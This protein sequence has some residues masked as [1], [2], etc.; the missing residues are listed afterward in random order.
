M[1]DK[2]KGLLELQRKAK[3]MQ[4]MMDEIVVEKTSRDGK[5]RLSMNGNN[6]LRSLS[7]DDSLL[8]PAHKGELEK[9]LSELVSEAGE[10]IR[11]KSSMQ[12][13]DMMKN[14]DIKIPGL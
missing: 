8:S 12:A 1:F 4:K 11:R 3:E 9:T 6:T 2:M 14:L 7:I 10:E 13:M 5:I